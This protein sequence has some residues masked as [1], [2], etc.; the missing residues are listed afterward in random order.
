MKNTYYCAERKA[1][2]GKGQ[3]ERFIAFPVKIRTGGDLLDIV[4]T[5]ENVSTVIPC[6]TLKEAKTMSD[7]W[8]EGYLKNGCY[9]FQE[10]DRVY[11]AQVYN[12]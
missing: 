8:N 11:P 3:E 5:F 4:R 1:N 7:V 10:S 12:L 6:E 2:M 9:V